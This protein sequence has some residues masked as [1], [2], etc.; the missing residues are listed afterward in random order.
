MIPERNLASGSAFWDTTARTGWPTAV[1]RSKNLKLL[2]YKI[3][4]PLPSFLSLAQK[5]YI[6]T[7]HKFQRRFCEDVPRLNACRYW[8][9]GKLPSVPAIWIQLSSALIRLNPN[10]AQDLIL[11]MFSQVLLSTHEFFHEIPKICWPSP[12]IHTTVLTSEIITLVF[13]YCGLPKA[14]QNFRRNHTLIEV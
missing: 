7:S 13:N 3:Q 8:M 11:E 14:A 1:S 4:L 2:K 10:Q 5:C 6:Q 12:M 9:A